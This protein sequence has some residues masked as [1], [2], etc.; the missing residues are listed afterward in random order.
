V[1]GHEAL[2]RAHEEHLPLE[3][4]P[5]AGVQLQEVEDPLPGVDV[6]QDRRAVGV[7]RAG[8]VGPDVLVGRLVQ[9]AAAAR[10]E[11][12]RRLRLLQVHARGKVHQDL[13][14]GAEAVEL[15]DGV[16]LQPATREQWHSDQREVHAQVVARPAAARCDQEARGGI[17]QQTL[18]VVEDLTIVGSIEIDDLDPGEGDELLARSLRIVDLGLEHEVP[19]A[20]S[21]QAHGSGDAVRKRRRRVE[22]H[23]HVVHVELEGPDVGGAGDPEVDVDRAGE[24]ELSEHGR[25]EE[26]LRAGGGP[27]AGGPQREPSERC[28]RDTPSDPTPSPHLPPPSVDRGAASLLRP[29]TP[30][31]AVHPIT[32]PKAD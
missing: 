25:P 15:I 31:V 30:R 18:L 1:P 32:A 5:G 27:R 3:I 17:R 21:G 16:R 7:E 24:G 28:P 20:A 10:L 11:Q 2:G 14:R 26:V 13:N 19:L 4:A 8:L 22:R 12:P 9:L 23:R 29:S 6:E